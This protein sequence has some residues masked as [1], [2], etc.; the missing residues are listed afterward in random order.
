M[1]YGRDKYKVW[2]YD[3]FDR[4]CFRKLFNENYFDEDPFVEDSFD[5]DSFHGNSID[6]KIQELNEE[7]L[8]NL[9]TI[10]HALF[11]KFYNQSTDNFV[12]FKFYSFRPSIF[13][14]T[15]YETQNRCVCLF[16]ERI[17]EPNKSKLIEEM[18]NVSS[19]INPKIYVNY[20]FFDVNN[21]KEKNPAGTLH[22]LIK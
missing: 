11:G 18:T 21:S 19:L 17:I 8:V 14:R 1:P 12:F 16:P 4:S 22:C 2:F 6:K 13:N 20:Y 7:R 10:S 3:I 9:N 15:W 5:G